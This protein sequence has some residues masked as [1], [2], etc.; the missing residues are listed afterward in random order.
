MLPCI[1]F[2]YLFFK[3]EDVQKITFE[4]LKQWVS[5]HDPTDE[6]IEDMAAILGRQG[7]P[8]I[9]KVQQL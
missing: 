2:T 8:E 3:V 5:K 1:D 9:P 7:H 4:E 6:C